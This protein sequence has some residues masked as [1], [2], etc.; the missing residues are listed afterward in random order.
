MTNWFNTSTWNNKQIDV[1]ELRQKL[2][3]MEE[4]KKEVQLLRHQ[5]TIAEEEA[6]L[7]TKQNQGV[8]G[9]LGWL[10]WTL[11]TWAR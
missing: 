2:Q 3:T 11:Q 1:A 6:A 4:L 10:V 8:G 7:R 9:L 5:K